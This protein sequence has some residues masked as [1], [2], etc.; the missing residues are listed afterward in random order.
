MYGKVSAPPRA[1]IPA[2]IAPQHARR[3]VEPPALS[4]PAVPRAPP[5]RSPPERPSR[6]YELPREPARA[7]FAPPL[8]RRAFPR[9]ASARFLWAD[10]RASLPFLSSASRPLRALA[11]LLRSSLRFPRHSHGYMGRHT[12]PRNTQSHQIQLQNSANGMSNQWEYQ[13]ASPRLPA[14]ATESPQKR[15]TTQEN[16]TA[17]R[18]AS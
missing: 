9:R 2:A 1:S 17:G 6:S 16:S 5:P 15:E 4:I 13:P 12:S 7:V 14:R 11:R 10:L 18:I 8:R 3:P